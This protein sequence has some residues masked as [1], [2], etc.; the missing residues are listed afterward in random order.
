M[1]PRSPVL[2]HGSAGSAGPRSIMSQPRNQTRVGRERDA[3]MPRW[4]RAQVC[5]HGGARQRQGHSGLVAVRA[6]RPGTDRGRRH[7]SLERAAPHEAGCDGAS[8]DRCRRTRRRR[9]GGVDRA[10]SARRARLEPRFRDRR[11]PPKR[12]P[13][14]VLLGELRHRCGDQP[15]T[16]R[17]RSRAARLVTPAVFPVRARLQPDGTSA[18]GGG[19]VRRVRRKT[20]Q[21][22]RRHPGGARVAPC[23]T[24][25]TRQRP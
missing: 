13:G 18:R 21:P 12:T 23:A 1:S 19:P 14:R 2:D 6:F 16:S 15:R 7:L 25:T 10:P 20:D 4:C 22:S 3:G 17:R 5:D 24:T 11:V 9:P 8:H